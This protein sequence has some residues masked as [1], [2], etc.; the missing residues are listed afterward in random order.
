MALPVKERSGP[1]TP[2]P[3][4]PAEPS[5]APRSRQM[6]RAAFYAHLWLGVI[7]TILTIGIAASWFASGRDRK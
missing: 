4:R 1:V 7:F 5:P 2:G 3:G 6:T